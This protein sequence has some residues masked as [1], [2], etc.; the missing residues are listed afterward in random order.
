VA[1]GLIAF[2]AVVPVAMRRTMGVAV[3]L[4]TVGLVVLVGGDVCVAV[5]LIAVELVVP[6]GGD[7][8]ADVAMAVG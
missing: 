8:R 3:G 1:V 2:G 4:T 7:I 6:V 5:G